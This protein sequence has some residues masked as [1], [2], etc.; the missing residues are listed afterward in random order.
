MSQYF[1]CC[2][3]V[4]TIFYKNIVNYKSVRV[5]KRYYLN[6][7]CDTISRFQFFKI[8]LNYLVFQSFFL[9]IP[10]DTQNFKMKLYN[11]VLIVFAWNWFSIFGYGGKARSNY[12]VHGCSATG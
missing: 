5:L 12:N 3:I 2:L 8:K 9:K 7:N 11:W 1:S 4:V 10:S 6:Y